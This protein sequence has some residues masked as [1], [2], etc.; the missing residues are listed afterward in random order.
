MLKSHNNSGEE[1]IKESVP[2]LLHDVTKDY[3]AIKSTKTNLELNEEL[4]YSIQLDYEDT[5]DKL[6]PHSHD[7]QNEAHY[8][9]NCN[10]MKMIIN[11][12][13]IYENTENV[14]E[15]YQ[16]M[17]SKNYDISNLM[18]DWY[19]MRTNHLR[20]NEQD[21]K[22]FKNHINMRCDGDQ[23]CKQFRRYQR[24]REKET[25]ADQIDLNSFILKD[26]LDSIHSF[27]FHPITARK[28]NEQTTIVSINLSDEKTQQYDSKSSDYIWD[29]VA[30]I[31]QCTVSQI[32]CV[33]QTVITDLDKLEEYQYDIISYF[34]NNNID[35][36]K[37]S[38]VGRKVFMNDIADILNNKKLKLS[39]AKLRK[40]IL[41]FDI[42]VFTGVT[43]TTTDT[44][45]ENKSKQETNSLSEQCSSKFVTKMSEES[46]AV[47]EPG[48]YS[49][50]T[51]YKY[52]K[53]LQDHPLY[54]KPKF[55]DLKQELIE[56]FM[57]I[58]KETDSMK[59]LHYQLDKIES[60][61]IS[62]QP[63]LKDF[64]LET[65]TNDNVST[66]WDI[67]AEQKYNDTTSKLINS[68][69]QITTIITNLCCYLE[70]ASD[71]I[72]LDKIYSLLH[73]RFS[74]N[75]LET[76]L[77][78]VD[79]YD[80]LVKVI[81]DYKNK[82]NEANESLLS[83]EVLTVCKKGIFKNVYQNFVNSNTIEN[84]VW[85]MHSWIKA[86]CEKYKD[87]VSEKLNPLLLSKKKK[88]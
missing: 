8:I 40:N 14:E 26:Q 19:Q 35:G 83:E 80:D 29:N 69:Q 88:K 68:C 3:D 65:N 60:M 48:Y 45:I 46:N 36:N 61:N 33:L 78:T 1:E 57:R 10:A 42:S 37:L 47:S 9:E 54:V 20:N 56:Y 31:Q 49:F 7:C 43:T 58:N 6:L 2:L 67:D 41:N 13:H 39:L 17:L 16:C 66:L 79:K 12:L 4:K 5:G 18:E 27:I 55:N 34:K 44:Q 72:L 84:T 32:I 74:L 87:S 15:I 51:Q 63:I 81:Y 21:T 71:Q 28:T 75:S 22:W 50:G 64:V 24:D 11:L 85:K 25:I 23:K 52:T 86:S 82:K 70:D 30:S 77:N 62:V 53:N 59:L 76:Y 73:L 38:K